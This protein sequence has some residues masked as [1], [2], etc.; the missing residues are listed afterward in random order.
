M[1]NRF[2]KYTKF[3]LSLLLVLQTVLPTLTVVAEEVIDPPITTISS[4]WEGTVFGS[5]G[6]NDKITA[7]NFEIS[8]NEDGTVKV[9]SGN[10]RGKLSG[11]TDGIAYYY[12]GIPL[13]A[14]FTFST[15]ATVE[16]FADNNQVGFGI[17]L[18]DEV[19][20]YINGDGYG[21]GDHLSVGAVTKGLRAFTKFDGSYNYSGHT[22]DGT[23]PTPGSS[24]KLSVQKVGDIYSVKI[25]GKEVIIEDYSGDVSFVGLFTARNAET[26]YSDVSLELANSGDVTSLVVNTANAQTN[27]LVNEEADFSGLEV[28]ANL[29]DGTSKVLTEADYIVTGFDTSVPGDKEVTIHYGGQTIKVPVSVTELTVTNL[30]IIY[31]PAKTTY[32]R[33]DSFLAD[34]LV[35]E[36][37]YNNG[38]TLQL[39]PDLYDIQVPDVFEEA[40]ELSVTIESLQTA[41]QTVSF[42]VTVL[43]ASLKEVV[44]SQQPQKM[45]YFLG[46]TLDTTGM[47][48]HATYGE[49]AP[50]RLDRS[51]YTVSELDTT[52]AGTKTLSVTYKGM[53]TDLEL[54][55]KEKEFTGIAIET[56][57]KTTYAVGE[58][59]DPTGLVVVK[60]YD[61]GEKDLLL[62]TDYELVIPELTE[63]GKT[64]VTIIANDEE[65]EPI[66][67]EV[68]VVASEAVEWH[69]IQFGQSTSS[70]KNYFE[71]KEDGSV[72]LVAL[73]GAGKVTGDHDGITFYYTEMD[74]TL[75]NFELSAT[76]DVIEYAKS[77][78]HDG[79][80]SF[81]MMVRDAIGSEGDS[82]VFASNVAAI[83][84]YSGGTRDPNGIQLFVRTG[85]ESSDG[86]GS[87]GIQARMLLQEDRPLGEYHLTLKKTNSGFVGSVNNGEET[88]IFEPEI[89]NVQDEK[90]YVGFYTARLATIDVRDILLTKTI[91]ATDAPKVVPPAEPVVADFDVTSL[92]RTSD[93]NYAVRLHAA[94]TGSFT[95][96]QG[97]EV[98]ARELVVE[99]G[100]EAVIP[101]ALKNGMNDFSITF[102]PDDTQLL[103]SYDRVVKN[104]TVEHRSYTGDIIVSP[105]G[106]PTGEGTLESP[107]DVDTAIDFVQAGQKIIVQDGLYLRDSKLEIKKHNNGTPEKMKYLVAAE[108]AQPIFDFDLKTEG[109][110]LSGN[111]WH[112][113][114]FDFRRS[115]GNTRG[116]TVGGSHNIIELSRFYLNGDTGLQISRTDHSGNFEDW[117]SHNLMLNVTSFDNRD[118]SNNNADGFAAK[119]T[120]GEGNIFRGAIAYNNVD[121]GWDLYT[122]VGSGKIGAVL[123]EDSIAFN[124]GFVSYSDDHRGD[125]NGFKLGGEGVHVPHIIRNSLAF[126]NLTY[127]FTSNSNPGVIAENNRAF[128]NGSGNLSFTTYTHIP[129]DFTI[130]GFVS[131]HKRPAVTTSETDEGFPRD[132]YPAGM[133]AENNYF[134]DGT[135]SQNI[136]GVTLT[137]DN[138]ESLLIDFDEYLR[139]EE[140]NIIWG[141]FMNFIA[142]IEEEPDAPDPDPEVPGQPDP[143]PEGPKVP[144]EPDPDPGTPA[145]PSETDPG[146]GTDGEADESSDETETEKEDEEALP[147]AG[148][149]RNLFSLLG[150]LLLLSG[151][152]LFILNK[153]RKTTK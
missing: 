92:S 153:E 35:V 112:I 34:G 126:G 28:T 150:V 140:G 72:R 151:G 42:P 96:K 13:N 65:I 69:K 100:E 88:T 101:T 29:A 19:F 102:I 8:E 21:T 115:A 83:G 52:T 152:L 117:P 76:I 31:L 82:S 39:A 109:G 130:D 108:G 135:V 61:N 51:D 25:D 27:Y 142:P 93:S 15:V 107:L 56:Y 81:G 145:E 36:A 89:L 55:V 85:V 62:E 71:I 136:S 144:G 1:G 128:N 139:D 14:D 80:E 74:A 125:G 46:E 121:D 17:M 95:V 58:T 79:Q 111:Y 122:K 84:G 73:E 48:V 38:D 98:I 12:K 119:L 4:D 49:E 22:L 50:I 77:P 123:I 104:F 66:Q 116:F 24:Y 44:I 149:A 16:N 23:M 43:D 106:L 75:E 2:L 45:T 90:M 133:E 132:R 11:G 78:S 68:S 110:V 5:V 6:G 99:A 40:G 146:D 114:G 7:E 103:T 141:S 129:T 64:Q 10:N 91:A 3:S 32:Y 30:R 20:S 63:V 60:E 87:Q 86:A 59:F 18:R 33:G 41:G 97:Q 9:K 127:G 134:H 147:D 54:V 148:M 57:P 138:F 26:L 131:Y 70:A 118:P 137:D 67:L 47:I 37:D 53:T 120:S 143:T 124:N 105:E 94:V 113:K